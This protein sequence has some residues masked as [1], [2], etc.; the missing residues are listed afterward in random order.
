M[1]SP[2]SCTTEMLHLVYKTTNLTNGRYYIGIHSTENINDGYLGS[3]TLLA[4]AV[5]KYGRDNFRRDILSEWK[6]RD[7]SKLEEKR[8]VDL[9][10]PL[11][12]NMVAGGVCPPNTKGRKR[13]PKQIELHRAKM[14]GRKWSEV[15]R[16]K[17]EGQPTWNKGL[18]T[19]PSSDETKMKQS[20]AMMG[21]KKPVVVCPYC[22][23]SG[24]VSPMKRFHFDNCKDKI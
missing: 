12:Y 14:I 22:N 6:T 13:T 10:D 11:I 4:K 20:K 18:R 21:R 7:E 19:G 15:M 24:G 17:R 5:I 8:L 23:K 3:G 2:T 9:T 16:S 1:T